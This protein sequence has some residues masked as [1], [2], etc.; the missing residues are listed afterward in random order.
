MNW[1]IRWELLPE[2]ELKADAMAV[3]RSVSKSLEPAPLTID[4]AQTL[5]R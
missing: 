2:G 4:I 1:P 3:M 5:I